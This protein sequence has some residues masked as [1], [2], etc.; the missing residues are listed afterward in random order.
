MGGTHMR[1]KIVGIIIFMLL[2]TTLLPITVLAGDEENPEITDVIGDA[3]TY[4]DINKAWFYEDSSTPEMLYTT[5]KLT[6]PSTIP[7]KQHLVVSWEMNGE[8]YAS[9][10]AIG[11]SPTQWLQY[12]SIIGRGSFGDPEPIV[13]II[14]GSIDTTKGTVTFFVPKSTIGNPAPGDVLTNT[15][16][17]CFERFGFW[18]SLGFYPPFRYMIFNN[19]LQKWQV[20][21]TAP[22]LFN[23]EFVYGIDYVI[24]Y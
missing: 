12:E 13:S 3:R 10:L 22:D 16:S 23:G 5:I 4:L 18:G 15:Q 24:Q 2:T 11:Y 20:E 21:D 17:Q 19:M 6:R 7:F 14:Q 8:R 9:M 1:K